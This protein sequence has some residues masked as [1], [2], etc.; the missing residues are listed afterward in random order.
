[1]DHT[2]FRPPLA[3]EPWPLTPRPPGQTRLAAPDVSPPA[4][5]AAPSRPSRS[6][7]RKP[8]RSPWRPSGPVDIVGTVLTWTA[9]GVVT[10]LAETFVVAAASVIVV[11]AGQAWFATR[12]R[13]IFWWPLLGIALLV[14]VQQ[15]VGPAAGLW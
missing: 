2:R 11:L 1:M 14:I 12:R 15:V 8:A 6:A 9:F 5:P 4:P 3:H 7:L 10:M 13:H